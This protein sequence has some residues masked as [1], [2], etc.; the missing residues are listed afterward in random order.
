MQLEQNQAQGSAPLGSSLEA[1]ALGDVRS[2]AI[3]SR[4][5]RLIRASFIWPALLVVL[6]LSIFPLL[7]SLTLAL[8]RINFVKG[9]FDVQFVGLDNFNKLV[10]GSSRTHFLGVLRDP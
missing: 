5:E 4:S 8:T 3:I 1:P 9:G 2:H 7:A 10:F 6:F